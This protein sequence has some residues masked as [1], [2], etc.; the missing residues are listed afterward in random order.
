MVDAKSGG[1]VRYASSMQAYTGAEYGGLLSE[2]G[3]GDVRF[4]PSMGGSGDEGEG[5]LVVIA[6]R[7]R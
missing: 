4:L 6:S 2:C 7:K 1:V 5:G 3:F